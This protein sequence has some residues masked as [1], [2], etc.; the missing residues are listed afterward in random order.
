ME[1]GASNFY[2]EQTQCAICNKAAVRIGIPAVDVMR[3]K[4]PV[5]CGFCLVEMP[6][7]AAEQTRKDADEKAF[8]RK[9]TGD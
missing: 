5:V 7:I 4:A 2:V 9:F 6:K 1:T 3:G 8:R